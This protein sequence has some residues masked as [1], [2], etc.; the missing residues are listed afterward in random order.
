MP[1]KLFTTY[2]DF[3]NVPNTG[4]ASAQLPIGKTIEQVHLLLGGTTFAKSNITLVRVR[5][6]AK[7]ILELSAAQL[8]KLLAYRG[9]TVTSNVVTIDFTEQFGRDLIDEVMGG[10]DTSIGITSLSLEVTISGATSPTIRVQTVQSAPQRGDLL[11]RYAGL[12]HTVT[13]QAWNM[14]TAGNLQFLLP[15]GVAGGLVKR[16][17]IE[18]GVANNVTQASLKQG[19]IEVYQS[20]KA[21]NDAFLTYNRNVPQSNWYTLDMI[22]DDNARNWLDATMNEQVELIPTLGAAD[23]GFV[24][25]E[26]LQTLSR[27]Q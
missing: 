13:R 20:V 19:G 12:I 17:H 6:N 25:V 23:S 16:L 1:G 26:S 15:S 5:A 9:H 2:T 14:S 10:F 3:A 24:I 27:L 11:G 22:P 18:H 21:L 8:D 4:I 7:T